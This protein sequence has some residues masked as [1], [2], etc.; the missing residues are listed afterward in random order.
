[1]TKLCSGASPYLRRL[2]Y[3]DHE[4]A[5]VAVYA[6]EPQG[7][8]IARQVLRR[9]PATP[10]QDLKAQ[11]LKHTVTLNDLYV[12]LAEGCALHRISPARHPFWWISTETAGLPWQQR[13]ETT[14]Q[15][16][17]RRIVPDAVLELSGERTRI[18]LECE[19]GGHPLVRGDENALGSAC[20]KLQ[21]YGAFML[22]GGQQTF[23]AQKYPDG[24]KA[25]LVFLVHSAERAANLSK[26]IQ[27]WHERNRAAPLVAR[28]LSFTEAEAHFCARLRLPGQPDQTIPLSRSDLKLTCAF[29]AEVTATFK[30]VRH[31]VRANPALKAQGCPYPEYSTEFERM[32]ALAERL[33]GQIGSTR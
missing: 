13:N 32:V 4:G 24:W 16:E 27:D 11:F 26:I 10:M 14:G 19:M 2:Q 30:A 20:S 15:I 12:A 25:E 6:A 8:A 1:V 33:R 31:F 5:A 23:Y 17:E 7:H 18:F 3:R 28:A 21:R 22:E 29:V 9:A